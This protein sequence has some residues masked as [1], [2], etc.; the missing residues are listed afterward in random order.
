MTNQTKKDIAAAEGISPSAVSQRAGPRRP[1]PDRRGVGVSSEP[2]VSAFAVMLIAHG[3]RRCDRR[4]TDRSW[5]PRSSRPRGR[6]CARRLRALWHAGD[7]V[8]LLIAAAASVVWV[9]LCAR[10]E[11]TGER[12][13]TPLVVFGAAVGLLILLSGWDSDVAGLVAR[14]S[15][16][17][18]LP[19]RRRDPRPGAHGRRGC[20]APDRHR[21]S[22][23]AVGARL[24]RRGQAGRG[25][26]G[27]GS[28]QGRAPAG[29]DG[30]AAD[31]RPRPGRSARG[32]DGGRRRQEHHPV[33]GDQR[34][35][36]PRKRAHRDR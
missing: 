21:K 15:T 17:A 24:G 22:A 23:G 3:Y 16:W 34:P 4:L 11:R 5:V 9:V 20:A 27:I 6:R 29:P 32:R 8:L 13:L 7:I 26:T 2:P 25:A 12:E 31:P 28:A 18:E 10:A 33:P 36:G 14:W 19:R 30:T 35:E 1:G